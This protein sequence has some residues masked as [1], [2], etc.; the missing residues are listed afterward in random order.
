MQGKKK[1]KKEIQILNKKMAEPQYEKNKNSIWLLFKRT[2]QNILL[3]SVLKTDI[4]FIFY[5]ENLEKI[6]QVSI[7]AKF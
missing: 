5:K 7:Q 4:Y 1:G 2:I 6:Y 3:F